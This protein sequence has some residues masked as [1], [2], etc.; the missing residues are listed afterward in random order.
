MGQEQEQKP[1]NPYEHMT[2][3]QLYEITQ[4][5]QGV[6]RELTKHF[7]LVGAMLTRRYA[8]GLR[9]GESS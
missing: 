1:F 4:E 3:E 5:L 6:Q 7:D 8:E 9:G 2:T